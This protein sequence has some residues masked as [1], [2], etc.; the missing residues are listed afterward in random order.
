MYTYMHTSSDTDDHE[1][2]DDHDGEN[3]EHGVSYE[4]DDLINVQKVLMFRSFFVVQW[5]EERRREECDRYLI[6]DTLCVK[7]QPGRKIFYLWVSE[8]GREGGRE[9]VCVCASEWV[10]EW[11]CE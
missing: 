8:C 7:F 10:K 6:T 5:G 9:G 2:D 3:V 4:G 11:V 1:E